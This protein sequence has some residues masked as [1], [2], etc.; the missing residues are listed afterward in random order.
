MNELLMDGYI[1]VTPTAPQTA[2]PCALHHDWALVAAQIAKAL[3]ET[4][5]NTVNVE[6]KPPTPSLLSGSSSDQT[7]SNTTTPITSPTTSTLSTTVNSTKSSTT[8]PLVTTLK[9]SPTP[10]VVT[11]TA[12]A[13]ATP[14]SPSA[15]TTAAVAAA[16]SVVPN[17]EPRTEIR[18]GVEWVS[19]VYSHHRVLRRY[20]IRTDVD[21]VDLHLLDD[22]FKSENCVSVALS[23][24]AMS[25]NAY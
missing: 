19:F 5:S 20:S 4:M 13:A 25:H 15:T 14:S 12:N 17:H 11:A 1:L 8:P 9:L 18:E 22:K 23:G 10:E 2:N 24:F 21:Q 6:S 16:G 3:A 7:K